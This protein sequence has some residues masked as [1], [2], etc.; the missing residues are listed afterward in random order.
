[1]TGICKETNLQGCIGSGEEYK[2]IKV[3]EDMD[4][5]EWGILNLDIYRSKLI[6]WQVRIA[7]QDAL[8]LCLQTSFNEDTSCVECDDEDGETVLKETYE[9]HTKL[10]I[11]YADDSEEDLSDED[12]DEYEDDDEYED[13]DDEDEELTIREEMMRDIEADPNDMKVIT[14]IEAF[15]ISGKRFDVY[16]MS[17][18]SDIDDYKIAKMLKDAICAGYV[19]DQWMKTEARSIQIAEF[20]VDDEIYQI[21]WED[22]LEFSVEFEKPE[23]LRYVGEKFVCDHGPLKQPFCITINDPQ[24]GLIEVKVYGLRAIYDEET[25]GRGF[26]F[27]EY[28]ASKEIQMN[29]YKTEYLDGYYSGQGASVCAVLDST[30]KYNSH[31]FCFVGRV[32]KGCHEP[33]EIELFSYYVEEEPDGQ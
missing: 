22:E 16:E 32:E 31:R 8:I 25:S 14:G 17:N 3:N 30:E 4:F 1:M 33:E 12:E 28:E 5:K 27:V 9:R 20:T 2:T 24:L 6:G 18:R 26:L 13:E 29:F 10:M 11:L 21:D 23:P 7:D 19:S 15:C